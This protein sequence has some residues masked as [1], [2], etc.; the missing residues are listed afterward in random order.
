MKRANSSIGLQD[1]RGPK[2]RRMYRIPTLPHGKIATFLSF[3]H[4]V[5][6]ATRIECQP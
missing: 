3:A 1:R 6:E 5:K 2:A 4:S